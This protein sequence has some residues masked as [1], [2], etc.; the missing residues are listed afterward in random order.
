MTLQS[1]DHAHFTLSLKN[2]LKCVAETIC[3]SMDAN[4]VPMEMTRIHQPLDAQQAV[5]SS[6]TSTER[7]SELE[8]L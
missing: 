1:K 5:L 4:A 3:S 8:T 2:Q 6:V 7:N